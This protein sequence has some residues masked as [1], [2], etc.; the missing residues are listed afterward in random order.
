MRISPG[1]GRSV[2]LSMTCIG[3]SVL[4]DDLPQ[5]FA[6]CLGHID[7]DVEPTGG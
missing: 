7:R 6:V 4:T 3:D 2:M 5:R 1:L